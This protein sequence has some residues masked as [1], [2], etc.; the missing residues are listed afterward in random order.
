M[1]VRRAFSQVVLPK[2]FFALGASE[3]VFLN[4]AHK[5]TLNYKNMG[6][7]KKISTFARGYRLRPET[8][9]LIKL[10]KDNLRTSHD[11]I[12]SDALKLYYIELKKSQKII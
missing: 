5:C 3:N 1:A 2:T 6:K 11:K 9:L 8:H 10:M 12:L 7:K 4:R